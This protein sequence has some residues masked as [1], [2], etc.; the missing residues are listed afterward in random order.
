ML[1]VIVF[2]ANVQMALDGGVRG[3][4]FPANSARLAWIRL[5]LQVPLILWA[6][7]VARSAARVST[8]DASS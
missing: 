4:G 2:P 6:I 7:S 5:P 1:F 3:A 8:A